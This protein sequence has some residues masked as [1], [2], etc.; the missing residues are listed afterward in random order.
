LWRG[1]G[2]V[3]ARTNTILLKNKRGVPG[4]L[5][6]LGR[7]YLFGGQKMIFQIKCA[8]CGRDMGKKEYP[9]ANDIH[10]TVSHSICEDCKAKVMADLERLKK[11]GAICAMIS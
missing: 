7:P 3:S 4:A 1:I 9:D 8:W 6:D 2:R 10:G 11:G 5:K